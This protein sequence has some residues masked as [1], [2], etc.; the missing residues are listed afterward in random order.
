MANKIR[1]RNEGSISK[2][3]NG[4][5]R[6]QVSLNGKRLSFSAKT[7]EECLVWLRKTQNQ[8]DEG[9]TYDRSKTTLAEFMA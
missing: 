3:S 2:R 7:K 9:L 8:I 1:G 6:A 4:K 5:W